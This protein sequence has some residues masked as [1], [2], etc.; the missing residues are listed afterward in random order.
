MAWRRIGQ[1]RLAVD[2]TELRGGTSLDEMAALVDWV[3]IGR[4]LAGISASARGAP[5]WP[6]L[7]FR[8]GE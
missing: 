4:R 6:P 3:E 5:G 7:A 1:E 2:G 8:L